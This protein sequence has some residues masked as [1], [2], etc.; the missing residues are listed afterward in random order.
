MIRALIGH[1]G[2]VGRSLLAQQSFD[3]L[4]DSK[5]IHTLP[6]HKIDQLVVAAPSGNRLAINR[7][8]E[9]HRQD[10]ANIQQ[11]ITQVY[12]AHPAHVVLFSTVDAV[13]AP[14]S[15]YGQNRGWLEQGMQR[16]HATTV[17]RLCTLVGSQIKK[18]ILYDIKHGQFLDQINSDSEFQWCLLDDLGQLVSTARPGTVKDIVSEPIANRDILQMFCPSQLLHTGPMA[19]K[20]CQQ[21]YYYSRQQIFQAMEAYLQ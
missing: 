20:Y 15:N 7:D 19:V 13:T 8:A 5:N 18:N 9:T 16:Y 6:E 4:F 3:L 11:I 10:Q 21:P 12:H 14:N 2:V 17:Y 1:S